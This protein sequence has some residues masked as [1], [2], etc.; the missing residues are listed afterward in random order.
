[1][2]PFVSVIMPVRNE[3][4]FIER[5]LGAMLRQTYPH[6]LYEVIVVDGMSDDGTRELVARQAAETDVPVRLVDNPS[7]IVPPAMNLGLRAA[8]G[9]VIVRM[10]GHTVAESDYLAACVAALERTHADNVGGYVVT[11]S[12]TAVGRAIALVTSSPFGIGNALFRH[13]GGSERAGD[14][15]ADT[16]PFGAWPRSAFARFGDFDEAFV[17]TQDSEYNYRTRLLG[18]RIVLCPE[19]RSTYYSRATI[20]R[21]GRQ[22]FEYGFWKTRLLY[23]LGGTLLPRHFAAPLLVVGLVGSLG[24]GALGVAVGSRWLAFLALPLPAVYAAFAIVGGTHV[25]L[26]GKALSLLPLI[27]VTFPIVHLTWGSGFVLG[28][29]RRPAPGMFAPL[30]NRSTATV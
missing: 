19:I 12:D 9:D 22:Y 14:R 6:D 20:R 4:A 27:W 17:R 8:T 3:G 16:V 21:L 11:V 5:S 30:P 1:M 7:H 29:L 18:G 25:A 2:A 10:D 26:K 28:L 13:T 23:K 24:L 15:D